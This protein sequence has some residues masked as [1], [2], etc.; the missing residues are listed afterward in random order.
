MK[1]GYLRIT[2]MLAGLA[3]LGCDEAP[4]IQPLAPPGAVIPKN[5]PDADPAQALG[6][7]APTSNKPP[8]EK[9]KV[10]STSTAPPTK[11]G[12]IKTTE[13]GVKYETLK[14]GTGPELKSGQQAEIHYEGKLEDGEVFDA[15]RKHIPPDPISFTIGTGA[16]IRGW[17]EAIPG[18]KVGEVRRLTIPS[19]MAYG[20][21][22]KPP[23]IPA[24]ATLI[25][26]VELVAIK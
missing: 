7:A 2:G 9:P 24:G 17:D 13:R 4:D 15:S 16:V 1:K 6:E 5:S 12:E 25:F 3:L 18:M 10:T 21:T 14:E 22:G 19:E 20:R 23:H 11:K 8:A 26:E